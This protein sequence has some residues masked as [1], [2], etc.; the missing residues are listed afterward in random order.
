MNFF[1]SGSTGDIIYSIPTIKSMGGGTLYL[2]KG[3]HYNTL[4]NLLKTLPY[5]DDVICT[6]RKLPSVSY[7]NLDVYRAVSQQ[8][9][10]WHLAKCHLEAFN[11]KYDLSQPWIA[12]HPNHQAD[13]VINRTVR[14]HDKNE[15]D[16]NILKEHAEHVLFIGDNYEYSLFCE[17]YFPIRRHMCKDGLEMAHIIKGSKLFIGNQSSAF[18]LA[19]A[20]KHPRIL[21]VCYKRNNCQPQSPNGHTYLTKP[22]MEQ[23]VNNTRNVL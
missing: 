8:H 9:Q 15:I 6:S 7:V 2:K 14:Y 23:Y 11:L 3:N 12:V 5:V 17:T 13:I 4:V 10:D 19:E 21:E 20:M 1:H 18:A 22:L 16:W